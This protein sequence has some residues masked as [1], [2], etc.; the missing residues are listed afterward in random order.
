[1]YF[2]R[3]E[4]AENRFYHTSIDATKVKEGD[5]I[6]ETSDANNEEAN[7][8]ENRNETTTDR[9]KSVVYDVERVGEYETESEDEDNEMNESDEEEESEK[10]MHN[11]EIE[12]EMNNEN[13][14]WNEV[15]TRS[16]RVV[17]PPER[18]N[19]DTMAVALTNAERNYY[20]RV[21]NP[22]ANY[23]SILE[24]ATEQEF[25][26]SEIAVVGAGLGG[27]FENTNELKVLNYKKAMASPDKEKWLEFI[28]EEFDRMT[29]YKVFR[30]VSKNRVPPKAKV[31]R[32]NQM[33][34]TEQG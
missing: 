1:M 27:G 33:E 22:S 15:R 34:L 10:E 26:E 16:G 13:D 32:R 20:D 3:F 5:D 30:P 18:M 21:A 25:A 19:I 29:K 6:N 24:D 17:R 28:K 4:P 8:E 23:Y 7:N 2:N 14:G 11:N 9:N 31:V 12:N